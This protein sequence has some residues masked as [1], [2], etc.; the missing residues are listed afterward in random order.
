MEEQRWKGLYHSKF[1]LKEEKIWLCYVLTGLFCYYHYRCY[2]AA[3]LE[4]SQPDNE[5]RKAKALAAA[6][7]ELEKLFRKEDF[8]RMKVAIFVIHIL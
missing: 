6:T 2:D 5:E 4:L 8:G 7:K 3:T 1:H